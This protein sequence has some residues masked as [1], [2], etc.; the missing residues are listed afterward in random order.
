MAT[1]VF[2][3]TINHAN[4][5]WFLECQ[6]KKENETLS[7]DISVFP[8]WGKQL[9]LRQETEKWTNNPGKNKA[10]CSILSDMSSFP[11]KLASEELVR[12]PM[13]TRSEWAQMLSFAGKVFKVAIIYM[14]KELKKKFFFKE[15]KKKG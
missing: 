6:V 4:P 10:E 9:K 2:F 8:L 3:K 5:G 15:K 13:K 11:W 14:F 1:T 7:K 12:E